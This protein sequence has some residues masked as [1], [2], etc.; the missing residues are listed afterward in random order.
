MCHVQHGRSIVVTKYFCIM[1]GVWFI[2]CKYFTLIGTDEA[3]PILRNDWIVLH[4]FHPRAHT[5][6]LVDGG[7]MFAHS[8]FSFVCQA[9]QNCR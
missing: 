2:K 1:V 9:S 3:C 6:S 8:E 5:L 7:E 4:P